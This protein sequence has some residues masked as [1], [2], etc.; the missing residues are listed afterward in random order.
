MS[1]IRCQHCGVALT[2]SKAYQSSRDSEPLV[3][4]A[5]CHSLLGLQGLQQPRLVVQRTT[6]PSTGLRRDWCAVATLRRLCPESRDGRGPHHP[7]SI[8]VLKEEL[9]KIAVEL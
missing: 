4:C 6:H 9:V 5:E 2:R 1:N 3:I 8:L 7:V